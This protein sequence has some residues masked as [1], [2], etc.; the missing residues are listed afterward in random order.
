MY[1]CCDAESLQESYQSDSIADSDHRLPNHRGTRHPGTNHG[2]ASR[3]SRFPHPVPGESLPLTLPFVFN[4]RRFIIRSW[5]THE[6]FLSTQTTNPPDTLEPTRT[7]TP[8]TGECLWCSEIGTECAGDSDCGT[9]GTCTQCGFC[10][11][12]DNCCTSSAECPTCQECIVNGGE[13]E[14]T[15]K[16]GSESTFGCCSTDSDCDR[17]ATCEVGKCTPFQCGFCEIC[18]AHV[19]VGLTE[20][21]APST[22]PTEAPSQ[23]CFATQAELEGYCSGLPP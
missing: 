21:L 18:N 20:C 9:C 13:T 23:L 16:L 6:S 22:S 14:G 3:S 1:P 17:C 15:C 10:E 12:I 19:C 11:P 5:S 4:L 7:P 8:C 2:V